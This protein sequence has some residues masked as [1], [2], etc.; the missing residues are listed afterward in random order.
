MAR[1]NTTFR[2][3]RAAVLAVAG[4]YFLVPLA[5]SV[6]FTVDVPGQGLNVDAYTRILGTD[7]FLPSLVLS[8]NWPQPRSPSFC[9]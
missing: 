8:S 2:P 7:G 5:A 1:L 4:L 9:C 3:G 6:I